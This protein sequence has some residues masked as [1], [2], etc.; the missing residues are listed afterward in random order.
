MNTYHEVKTGLNVSIFLK[1]D[2]LSFVIG[3]GKSLD[4]LSQ[5]NAYEGIPILY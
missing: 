2:P 1:S 4:I 5:A 3:G